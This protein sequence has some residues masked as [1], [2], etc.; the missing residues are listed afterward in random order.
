M[1]HRLFP[2]L[3]L[4]GTRRLQFVSPLI[5]IQTYGRIFKNVVMNILQNDK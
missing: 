5:P 1:S 4:V 3:I 2:S